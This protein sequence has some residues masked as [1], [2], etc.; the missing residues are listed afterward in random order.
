MPLTELFLPGVLYPRRRQPLAY[1]LVR[2]EPSIGVEV[3]ENLTKE[4][5]QRKNDTKEEAKALF[6]TVWVV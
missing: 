6:W 3:E 1:P 2:L 4:S 5:R